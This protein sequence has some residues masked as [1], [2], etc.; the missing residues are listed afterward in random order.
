[1]P[2][3]RETFTAVSILQKFNRV[4]LSLGIT[5]V[6]RLAKDDV[7]Y[8]LDEEG[9]EDDLKKALA[10]FQR[11]DSIEGQSGFNTL[12]L[13]LEHED[14]ELKYLI[15]IEM[16]RA[17]RIGEHPI[18]VTLNGLMKNLQVRSDQGDVDVRNLLSAHF[19]SQDAYDSCINRYKAQFDAFLDRIEQTI[20]QHI[21]IDDV[22][23]SSESRIIRP[24]EPVKRHD[25]WH[26]SDG[27]EPVYYGYYGYD[28]YF[29]YSW[30]WS[31]MC[32]QE[33]IYCH[34]CCVVDD[35]GQ[36]VFEVGEEGFAAGG[37][38]TLNPEA[39]IELPKDVD[40]DVHADSAFSDTLGETVR[41]AD[42]G[43]GGSTGWMGS[44]S[45]SD[46]DA[47]DGGGDGGG[48]GCGG[49]CGGE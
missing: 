38:N 39:P 29:F 26:R 17:H 41:T 9:R 42:I 13:V 27:H 32:H 25:Q 18:R 23:R 49:G 40:I 11:S 7:D 48:G 44:F 35:Q 34:D 46:G 20:R 10:S 8:Y 16:Q 31:D 4:F 37:T 36:T 43:A 15:Q 12:R 21:G 28:D 24:S 45:F 2:F 5:N 19:D 47:G 30:I 1:M 33:N 3:E 14:E 22:R 6:L